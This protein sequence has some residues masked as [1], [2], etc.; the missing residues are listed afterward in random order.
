[1]ELVSSTRDLKTRRWPMFDRE[2]SSVVDR[3]DISTHLPYCQLWSH[4]ARFPGD[5]S[6]HS[7]PSLQALARFR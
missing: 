7:K 6:R 1:M 3:V 2:G 4:T 5:C